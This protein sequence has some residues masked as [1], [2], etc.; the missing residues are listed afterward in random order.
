MMVDAAAKALAQ[1]FSPPFRSVLLK[2]CALAVALLVVIGIGLHHVLVWLV[3]AAGTWLETSAGPHAHGPVAALEVVLAV[4]AGLGL[5][6]GA[7]FLMPSVTSLAAS[8]FV[9]EI[10]EQVEREHY[11]TDPP[12]T[13]VPLARAI[14]EGV[15]AGLLALAVY[16]CAVPLLL[17]AGAGAVI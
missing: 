17:F 15:K 9:D 1:M 11:P 7:V 6:G 14:L 12:G 10:A 2:A 16:A 3:G 5:I 8:F 4:L 13:A